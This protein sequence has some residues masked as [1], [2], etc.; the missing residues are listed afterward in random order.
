MTNYQIF[1]DG[2]CRGNKN[3]GVGI[4]WLKNG[5]KV[6]E[7]SKGYKNTTN[8]QME[9]LAIGKAL[10]SIKK[11]IDSLEIVSDSEYALGCIFNLKWNPKKNVELIN[12]IRQQVITTQQL[13][14]DPITYTHT[15]G[16]QKDDSLYTEINNLCDKLAQ[17]ASKM[18]LE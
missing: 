16:H 11:P 15:R 10:A 18:I 17:N 7:Y 1:T 2:S 9:L 12:R 3:G 14:I 5:E 8:N 6:F 4:V 13:V